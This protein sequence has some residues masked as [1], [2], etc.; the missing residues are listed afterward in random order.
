MQVRVTMAK[1]VESRKSLQEKLSSK[2]GVMKVKADKINAEKARETFYGPQLPVPW[3]QEDVAYGGG[4]GGSGGGGGGVNRDDGDGPESPT[5]EVMRLMKARQASGG[6]DTFQLARGDA[7]MSANATAGPNSDT[8]TATAFLRSS[9]AG[10]STGKP[11]PIM[12]DPRP[13]EDPNYVDPAVRDIVNAH[14]NADFIGPQV[15]THERTLALTLIYY[16]ARILYVYT[17]LSFP[18]IG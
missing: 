13:H 8:A 16:Y 14:K 3:V 12:R 1:E 10:G 15:H 9:Y 4:G 5:R 17:Y 7:G 2:A 18:R 6:F 11:A